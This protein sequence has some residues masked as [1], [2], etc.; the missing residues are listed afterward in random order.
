MSEPDE[1]LLAPAEV[2]A[3]FHVA[4]KT[5][6]RWAQDGRLPEDAIV[7]TLGGHRR[8]RERVIRALLAEGREG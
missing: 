2:A 8:Y 5:V 7:R 1:P 3:L 6:Y 4:P